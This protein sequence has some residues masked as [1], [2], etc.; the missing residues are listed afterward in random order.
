MDYR[1]SLTYLHSLG[2]EVLAAKFGLESIKLL[3]GKLGHPERSFKSV[4]VAG[5]NG[6]GSVAAMIDSI[7]RA[8]G[9]RA[10]LFTSP[11]LV[12]IQ[13]RIRFMGA[14]ITEPDFAR[15]ASIVREAGE[16]LVANAR[17]S[18]GARSR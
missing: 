11:H 13:E 7:S 3:L 16:D 9:H 17:L 8:A 12:R 15:L 5:T 2:H 1:E 14:E 18:A 4:I 6:K 10:A